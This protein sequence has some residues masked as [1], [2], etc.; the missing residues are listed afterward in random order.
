MSHWT[1][2]NLCQ[3]VNL[4]SQFKNLWDRNHP[5]YYKLRCR[6]DSYNEIRKGLSTPG[7]TVTRVL[8]KLWD[9]RSDYVAELRKMQIAKKRNFHYQP[10]KIWFSAMHRFL[11]DSLDTDEKPTEDSCDVSHSTLQ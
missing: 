10:R 2:G 1:D 7:L 4:Y 6:Y 3:L 8:S 11:Y 5:C 9:L